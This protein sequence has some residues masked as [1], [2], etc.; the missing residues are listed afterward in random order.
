MTAASPFERAI[1]L[2][3]SESKLAQAT[4]Y[5]QVAINKARRR[6]S[7]SPAMALAVH[8]FTRGAVPA[9]ALRPD[10]WARPQDVPMAADLPKERGGNGMAA[11]D[12]AASGAARGSLRPG[13]SG[14][15]AARVA[16]LR[17]R[18]TEGASAGAIAMELG[19]GISRSAVLGK[20]YRLKLPRPDA[21]SRSAPARQGW[22][23][24]ASEQ[25][26]PPRPVAESGEKSALRRAFQALGIEPPDSEP[27]LRH[28][29]A[30]THTAFGVPCGFLELGDLTCRW[31]VGTPGHPDFVFCGAMA[32]QHH[33][34]C[35]PHCL[36]AYRREGGE[37]CRAP[38]RESLKPGA[39]DAA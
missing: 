14:W 9:S 12:R 20:V 32:F 35:L 37:R 27:D 13:H 3:G 22:S 17:R 34:Y 2:A 26:G 23:K 5:S 36:I 4:G 8:R 38:D 33:P 24:S 1:R 30:G 11:E 31:P 18:W 21:G 15:T 10:L 16:L 39:K 28:L 25:G 19:R 7:V 29:R 6:G